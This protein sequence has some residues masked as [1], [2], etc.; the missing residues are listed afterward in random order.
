MVSRVKGKSQP[1]EKVVPTKQY[2]QGRLTKRKKM[3]NPQAM[4][5]AIM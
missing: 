2:Q 4:T 5:Q 3:K 1:P